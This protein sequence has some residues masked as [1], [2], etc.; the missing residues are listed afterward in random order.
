MLLIRRNQPYPN[1]VCILLDFVKYYLGLSLR[2]HQGPASLLFLIAF[3]VYFNHT[4]CGIIFCL[5]IVSGLKIF[6]FNYLLHYTGIDM[7]IQLYGL[8]FNGR[9]PL[10]LHYAWESTDNLE[11]YEE[12]VKFPSK[13]KSGVSD[14]QSATPSM[15]SQTRNYAMST[16]QNN[17]NYQKD[18]HSIHTEANGDKVTR[19]GSKA[20]TTDTLYP[21][22]S[23]EVNIP[24][25]VE[26]E[27]TTA[28]QVHILSGPR[29]EDHSKTDVGITPSS[30]SS[31]NKSNIDRSSIGTR[32][33]SDLLSIKSTKQ[34]VRTRKSRSRRR[35]RISTRSGKILLA[36]TF[37]QQS[38]SGTTQSRSKTSNRMSVGLRKDQSGMISKKSP[39]TQRSMKTKL[40]DEK[41]NEDPTT[42]EEQERT[43]KYI[44][45]NTTNNQ[46]DWEVKRKGRTLNSKR[47]SADDFNKMKSR[48][49][50]R[51]GSVKDKL[52]ELENEMKFK[53]SQRTKTK[54]NENKTK[55]NKSLQVENTQDEN[56]FS[57]LMK[58]VGST[59]PPVFDRKPETS[60]LILQIKEH[61]PSVGAQTRRNTLQN[62]RLRSSIQNEYN[63]GETSRI[64]KDNTK[65]SDDPLKKSNV[66]IPLETGSLGKKESSRP[67]SKV[68][69][70][71]KGFLEMDPTKTNYTDPLNKVS[72]KNVESL[73]RSTLS[74]NASSQQMEPITISIKPEIRVRES[75]LGSQLTTSENLPSSGS[76][77]SLIKTMSD[78]SSQGTERSRGFRKER[79]LKKEKKIRNKSH[80]L[81]SDI[82]SRRNSHRKG[83]RARTNRT[84]KYS[85]NLLPSSSFKG[86][87]KRSQFS[88]FL[89]KSIGSSIMSRS[90]SAKSTTP[91]HFGSNNNPNNQRDIPTSKKASDTSDILDEY[92]AGDRRLPAK[93]RQTGELLRDNTMN[94][95]PIDESNYLVDANIVNNYE[96]KKNRSHA[97]E[98]IGKNNMTISQTSKVSK[99]YYK[100]D[101]DTQTKTI[102]TNCF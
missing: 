48:M 82:F 53:K 61:S 94:I 30:T 20:L 77:N 59:L 35:S 88:R 75:E 66:V 16:E 81:T 68:S 78:T 96:K 98:S 76:S 14:Q 3:Y 73:S 13:K 26:S 21:D 101:K 70:S 64:W 42:E 28:S 5:T 90:S 99:T 17:S 54:S 29:I 32:R 74:S 58:E 62:E 57:G 69:L 97:H 86:H 39:E 44:Y 33:K 49:D 38:V 23:S 15:T 27:G 79:N 80:M 4:S 56:K 89:E 46:A 51:N 10:P 92:L 34:R 18:V 25:G 65:S 31:S 71:S 67:N 72:I 40:T 100:Q 50:N 6:N 22:T 63:I 1:R 102:E 93:L 87:S 8:F 43:A 7:V 55:S 36:N 9:L 52:Y 45:G 11:H 19:K 24:D 37:S 83:K 47:S 12:P 60:G 84:D 95:S 2:Q 41:T 85:S 91:Q